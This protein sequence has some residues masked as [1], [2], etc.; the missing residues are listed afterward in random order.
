MRTLTKISA[1]I[2]FTFRESFAKKTFVTFF[3]LSTLLHLFFLLA[4]NV[5]IVDA[6][7]GMVTVLGLDVNH[8][9]TIDVKKMIIGIQSVLATVVFA[10]S[11]FLSI[12]STASLV[13]TML[14]RGRIDL[15]VSKPLSRAHILVGKYLG[16]LSI[17]MFNVAYLI[18]GTWLILSAKTDFWHFPYL[19]SIPM[20]IVAFAI[21]FALMILVG[22]TTRSTGVS[23][24]IAYSSVF[25][26]LFW[27]KKDTVYA[28]VSSKV[29][30][31]MLETI[32]HALPKTSELGQLNQA[33]VMNKP[34]DT[35]AP[36]WTSSIA[37]VILLL[38]AIF[39]F[40]K[41]DF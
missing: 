19:Y 24:M 8:A 34:I 10:G 27:E 6:G 38:T 11:I 18:G 5:D 7:L 16:G 25:F 28:V 13:P 20:V 40:H 29:Y 33:L 30:Y 1:L 32:Y 14:E 36:L 39:V 12:F 37:G 17:I 26:S 41:K 15:L 9:Q 35:W 3:A 23:V 31:Y 2:L 4:L 21:V 22:V